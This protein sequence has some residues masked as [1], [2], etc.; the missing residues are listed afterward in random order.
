M[1][2]KRPRHWT[3]AGLA[4]FGTLYQAGSCFSPDLIGQVFADQVGLTAATFVRG[5][6]GAA[7]GLFLG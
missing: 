5:L 4:L 1:D 7:F 6:V 2:T 3:W